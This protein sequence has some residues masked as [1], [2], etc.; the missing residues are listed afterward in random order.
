MPNEIKVPAVGESVTEGILVEWQVADGDVVARDQPLFEL[1]TDKITMTVNA[2]EAGKV[3]IGVQAGETVQVGQ[4]VGQLDTTVTGPPTHA[5]KPDAPAAAVA[6]PAKSAPPPAALPASAKSPGGA[7]ARGAVAEALSPSVRRMLRETSVDPGSVTGTG[8]GGRVT[9]ADVQRAATQP[10]P[11]TT[12]SAAARSASPGPGAGDALP[13]QVR[14][15]MSPLRKRIAERLVQAQHTAAML[16]TFNEADMTS[17]MELRA[18]YNKDGAFEKRH[19]VKLGFMSFFVKAVVEALKAVPAVNGYI[20]GEDII[21]N[22]YFDIGV[23]V[24]TEKGLVVPVIRDADQLDFAQVEQ[25]IG[26][27]A[28]RARKRQLT[29]EDLTGGVY[30][31]SNGGVYGSLLST[32]ILNPPQS[33]ILGMHAIKKRAM[34]MPDDSIQARPMMYLA[35]SYDHRLVDGS[36]AVTFLKRVVECIE[37]PERMLLS[38]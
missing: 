12:T 20:D 11:A 29:I 5:A 7:P 30:T 18:R 16:T 6:A 38:I 2:E 32:P 27:L 10:A 4:V 33:G 34:V 15:P 3:T 31:I 35:M 13:R 9:P 14:K 19:G 21:E 28:L 36:E 1:E 17:V 26:D 37:S 22:H 25:A 8:R 23:A 24:G